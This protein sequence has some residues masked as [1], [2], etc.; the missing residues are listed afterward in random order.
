M[1]E[2][3]WCE[4]L[5]GERYCRVAGEDR[6]HG[7]Y[8]KVSRVVCVDQFFL[9]AFTVMIL[10]RNEG[11]LGDARV[12]AAHAEVSAASGEGSIR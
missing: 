10:Q 8:Y 9:N 4:R 2:I 6:C 3:E 12:Y 7:G 11:N 1:S 5:W